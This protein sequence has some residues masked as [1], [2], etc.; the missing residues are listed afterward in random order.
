M[1]GYCLDIV[2]EDGSLEVESGS[3]VG[4]EDGTTTDGQCAVGGWIN[5]GEKGHKRSY[6]C[7]TPRPRGE[8]QI[9]L[10]DEHHSTSDINPRA[11]GESN[12]HT[13]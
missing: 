4:G 7:N 5:H 6:L 3:I 13:A 2:S 1:G 11:S 10:L 8:S 9:T 12:P